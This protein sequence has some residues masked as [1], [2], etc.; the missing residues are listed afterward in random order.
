VGGGPTGL[1]LALALL[2]SRIDVRLIE[3]SS[4]PH[5]GIRGTAITPRT[6]ELLSLLQAADNVLAVATPP[7]LM[8]IYG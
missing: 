7:L 8:A 2:R 3:R 4:V 5:E 6:L 1:V